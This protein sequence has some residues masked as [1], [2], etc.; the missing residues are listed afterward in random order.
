MRWWKKAL[1]IVMAVLIL[2]GAWNIVEMLPKALSDPNPQDALLGILLTAFGLCGAVF[3]FFFLTG[4]LKLM[5]QEWARRGQLVSAAGASL[6]LCTVLL[7][8]LAIPAFA[9]GEIGAG[10]FFAVLSVLIPWV[11]L[12]TLAARLGIVFPKWKKRGAKQR[13]PAGQA[14][15][16]QRPVRTKP[17]TVDHEERAAV[18]PDQAAPEQRHEQA[19]PQSGGRAARKISRGESANVILQEDFGQ[20]PDRFRRTVWIPEEIF[21]MRLNDEIDEI[22]HERETVD[23]QMTPSGCYLEM[24][25]AWARNDR[26]YC[27]LLPETSLRKPTDAFL[28]D[29]DAILKEHSF[30][31][32]DRTQADADVL[33]AFLDTRA[34]QLGKPRTSIRWNEKLLFEGVI[35][36]GVVTEYTGEISVVEIPEGV[37]EIGDGA[38]QGHSELTVVVI[39]KGVTRIG[40]SAF[41]NCAF[42]RSVVLPKSLT[43]IG[44][45][46]FMN[47]PQLQRPKITGGVEVGKL[48]FAGT[49]APMRPDAPVRGKKT[50]R[51]QKRQPI[52][53][54]KAPSAYSNPVRIAR[55]EWSGNEQNVN[56]RFTHKQDGWYLEWVQR[57]RLTHNADDVYDES[58]KLPEDFFTGMTTDSLLPAI[59]AIME[60]HDSAPL[61]RAL[62]YLDTLQ[63]FLDLLAA[64]ED[65]EK[66]FGVFREEPPL[67]P[68]VKGFAAEIEDGVIKQYTGDGGLVVIP[69]GVTAIG[70]HAFDGC[71][72]VTAVVI[73]EGVTHIGTS[74]FRNCAFL[75]SV[76]LPKSL[77]SIGA[78]AFMNCP[79]LQRPKIPGGVE[80]GKYAISGANK[81]SG[82]S[83]SVK[84]N[85]V[86]FAIDKRRFLAERAEISN[87]CFTRKSDGWYLEW[88]EFYRS[89]ANGGDVY[90]NSKK[91]PKDF[92][93]GKTMGELLNDIDRVMGSTRLPRECFDYE[94][95][96]EVLDCFAAL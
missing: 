21:T 80:I 16:V 77:L 44:R 47:C 24:E 61:P 67:Q 84:T 48:A 64:E 26:E 74:A 73:P 7:T 86:S 38:F 18:R 17:L 20:Q 52:K 11:L 42:L 63:E 51:T 25:D 19:K 90:D 14:S 58:E 22:I 56:L 96:Q 89:S 35:E 41:R 68:E 72:R 87:V 92:F 71:A 70:D 4:E 10:L 94:A 50:A 69:D 43:S 13:D 55:D 9:A 53:Q 3:A 49:A 76:V 66:I 91:L 1:C 30:W 79:Q 88:T 36:N 8:L 2:A 28:D 31:S 95:L 32:L 37:I 6:A 81:A 23:L 60:R 40:E 33:R 75:K 78:Y 93:A 45:Y 85:K 46:A 65:P 39:P 82:G 34:R 62:F 83:G 57:T 59:D 12:S 27:V 54:Q 5:K 29:V 15:S